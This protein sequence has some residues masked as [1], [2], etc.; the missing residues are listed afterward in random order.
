M[1]YGN[2]VEGRYEKVLERASPVSVGPL[3]SETKPCRDSICFLLFPKGR[4]LSE[5]DI[6][7]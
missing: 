4:V 6:A 7:S 2:G 1:T 3:L 5:V